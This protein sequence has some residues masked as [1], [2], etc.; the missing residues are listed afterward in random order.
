MKKKMKVAIIGAGHGGQAIAGHMACFGYEVWMYVRNAKTMEALRKAG[1]ITLTEG[2]T[3][4]VTVR[5]TNDLPEAVKYAELIM[6]VTPASSHN[7]VAKDIA[8]LLAD[9]Q[10]IIL[11]PGYFLGSLSFSHTL[12]KEGCDKDVT[13]GETE[14]LI[15]SCR[16]ERPGEVYIAG[17][18]NSLLV[19][20]FPGN[21]ISPVIEKIKEAYP[22]FQPARNILETTFGNVN[23]VLHAP[24]ALLNA[25][26]IESKREFLFY[27]EGGTPSIMNLEEKLDKERLEVARQFGIKARSI[28]EL[29]TEFYGVKGRTLYDVV[30]RNPAYATVKAPQGLQTRLIT[31]DVPMGLVPVASAAEKFRVDAPLHNAFIDLASALMGVDYRNQ[32]R[33]MENLGLAELN[34]NEILQ[35]L[36]DGY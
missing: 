3:G 2:E 7:D 24:I 36:D 9:G 22:Q 34:A 18:K 20:T 12:R 1:G 35:L 27:R 8:P 29:E 13:I 31:E 11:N 17:I 14:S 5:L 10:I 33:N 26:S 16:A 6:V 21:R 30:V 4:S 19:A 15:Y 23:L 25:G 32:G 28:K